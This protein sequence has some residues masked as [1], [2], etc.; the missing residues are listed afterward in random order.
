MKAPTA[1]ARSGRS[2]AWLVL[3]AALSAQ[4][5]VTTFPPA[6]FAQFPNYQPVAGLSG[7]LE[8][9]RSAGAR[10]RVSPRG[11][12]VA[13]IYPDVD[14]TVVGGSERDIPNA[15][16]SGAAAF[17]GALTPFTAEQTAAFR[18]QYGYD[19]TAVKFATA[20]IGVFVSRSNPVQGMTLRQLDSIFSINR[21]RGGPAAEQW[22]DLGLRG[23]WAPRPLILFGYRKES[24]YY[25]W[26]REAALLGDD[27]KRSMRDELSATSAVQGP[28]AERAGISY[29]NLLLATARTRAVSLGT[30]EGGL[31]APTHDNCLTQRYPLCGFIYIYA[32]TGEK[33][34][35]TAAG[36]EFIKYLL[37]REGQQAI[38][39]GAQYPISPALAQEQLSQLS[40]HAAAQP[41]E[42]K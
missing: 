14:V 42:P 29:S 19:P 28:A 6:F 23:E 13:A 12:R 5:Q 2:A 21:R 3:L 30:E 9:P 15:L 34:K 8:R 27:I 18:Q 16:I 26:F 20:G 41:P 31:Y 24:G 36:R 22:G 25:T 4:A 1:A 33:G 38:A 35:L 32:N 39:Q 40:T 17:L 7:E 11:G 10:Y 37:S